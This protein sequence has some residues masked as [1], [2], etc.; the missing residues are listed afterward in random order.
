VETYRDAGGQLYIEREGR[1]YERSN[2]GVVLLERGG[3]FFAYSLDARDK[4][5]A[6]VDLRTTIPARSEA[7]RW[8]YMFIPSINGVRLAGS[9]IVFQQRRNSPHDTASCRTGGIRY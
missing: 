5:G 3:R 1:Q 6:A 9:D 4:A 2:K 8:H 7:S